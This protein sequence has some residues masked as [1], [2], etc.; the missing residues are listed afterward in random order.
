M[1][2]DDLRALSLFDGLTDEQL[3]DLIAA[4]DEV[5]IEPG[6]ELF[7]EGNHGDHWWVLVEGA[8]E[9]VRRVGHEET[10]VGRMDIPGR[11]AG[12]FRA[13]DEHGV[14][15][16][17]ARGVTEGRVLRV[18]AADLRALTDAWFPFGGHIVQ[19][20]FGTARN[21]ESTVR[22]RESLVTLGTLAAGLAHELNNP[23]AAATR[24]AAAL[25]DVCQTLIGSFARL[26][27]GALSPEQVGALDALRGEIEP[28]PIVLD[29]LEA[30]DKEDELSTWLTSHDVER[31]W[32]IAPPLVAAGVDIAWCERVAEVLDGPEL[33]P[34]LE[35]VASTY[36]AKTLLTEVQ[37]ATR[38]VSELVDAVRSYSQMDR[39]SMQSIEITDGIESTLVMLGH[40]LRDGIVLVRDYGAD[41]PQIEA[42]PGE[43]NQVWTNL[44]DNAVDAMDGT[45]TLRLSTRAAGSG[46]VVEIGDT[47]PGMDPD[48]VARAFEAFYTTKDVGKGT[49]LGLDIARRIVEDRHGGAIMIDSKPGD[50]VLRVH[51]PVRARQS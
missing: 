39:A 7:H 11:W 42:Y 12:G 6:V 4:G 41:V 32:V 45:G 17:T 31:D 49:G 22:Q 3:A 21:I 15:L 30:S 2:V 35:W 51:L 40:R 19:G 9:L 18:P 1:R 26:C 34:G 23:A 44:I 38:H 5:P 29:P 46:V 14:Y 20:V 24:S 37:D 48:V 50:T 36:S 33:G 28:R 13:W 25:D 43:L 8:I 16:A 10:V 47:G 27:S